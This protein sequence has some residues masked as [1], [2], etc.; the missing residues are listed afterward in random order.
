MHTLFNLVRE[1]G[2]SY[3]VTRV[4]VQIGS[5]LDSNKIS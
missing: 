2:I 1:E 5:I 4:I 3:T